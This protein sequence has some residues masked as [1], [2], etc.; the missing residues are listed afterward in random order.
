MS[1]KQIHMISMALKLDLTEEAKK[2]I[3]LILRAGELQGHSRLVKNPHVTI[4]FIE[5][6]RGVDE[7]EKIGNIAVEFL[8][9]YLRKTLLEFDVNSCTILWRHVLLLPTEECAKQL[10]KLNQLL[11]QE[12]KKKGYALNKKTINENYSPH[13]S[14][15]KRETSSS[16][17]ERV[18][19]E[20][21]KLKGEN[22]LLFVL[23]KSSFVLVS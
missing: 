4:G 21:K 6:L 17:V 20:I 1:T 15:I 12:L 14:L 16:R 2:I 10:K 22:S 7:A 23:K 5:A 13:L 9:A 18:N 3:K 8:D 11:E 19:Q